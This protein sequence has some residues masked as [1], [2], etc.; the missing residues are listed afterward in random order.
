MQVSIN[1]LVL[2]FHINESPVCT[3]PVASIFIVVLRIIS[4]VTITLRTTQQLQFLHIP[5][6]L[7]I[8]ITKVRSIFLI[9]TSPTACVTTRLKGLS[10][11]AKVPQLELDIN[12]TPQFFH[13]ASSAVS[14]ALLL[15][16]AA[17][18]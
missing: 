12:D 18:S 11:K 4:V 10:L 5:Q 13:V 15:V 16:R 9:I 2:S 14:R 3:V 7:P 1:K 8:Q 17:L 6:R